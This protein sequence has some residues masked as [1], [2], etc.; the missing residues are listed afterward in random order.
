MIVIAID[1]GTVRVGVA[2]CDTTVGVAFPLT[3]LEKARDRAVNE[4]INILNERQA[5][6]LVV[7]L[8]L[9]DDGSRSANCDL[10]ERFVRRLVRRRPI[11]VQYV[12]EAF[13]SLEAA[14]RLGNRA[15]AKNMALDAYAACVIL[16]RFLAD[17]SNSH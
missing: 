14:E 8:P 6:L 1:V 5:E 3:V 4:L 12:D 17:S 11:D 10:V 9:A 13:S 7:G 15:R 16:E 2:W